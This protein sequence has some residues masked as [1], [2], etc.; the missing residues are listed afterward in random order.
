[1]A[2]E[3]CLKCFEK[4]DAVL[5]EHAFLGDGTGSSTFGGGDLAFSALSGWLVLPQNFGGGEV[6]AKFLKEE[7]FG[8]RFAAFRE[9]LKSRRAFKHVELCYLEYR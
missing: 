1:M 3:R 6:G 2:E 7:N 8:P 4:A 5:S 9:K